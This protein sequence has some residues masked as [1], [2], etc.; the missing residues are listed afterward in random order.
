MAKNDTNTLKKASLTMRLPKELHTRIADAA[1]RELL[2][3]SAEA[4]RRLK[5]TFDEDDLAGDPRL[6]ALLRYMA[7]GSALIIET[8][9]ALKISGTARR[10]V[11]DLWLEAVERFLPAITKMNRVPADVR[12]L[13]DERRKLQFAIKRDRE[14]RG[15]PAV[16]NRHLEG[17]DLKSGKFEVQNGHLI[18][19]AVDALHHE[20]EKQ[21][22]EPSPE[23]I[24]WAELCDQIA[25]INQKRRLE[26]PER[27]GATVKLVRAMLAELTPKE[28][29]AVLRDLEE[30]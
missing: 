28:R 4:E 20:Y 19:G 3:V 11:H 14:A 10:E 7:A 23:E 1:D 15:L 16:P 18:G 5:R 25:I 13:M 26:A 24:R 30:S 21:I 27:A 12:A 22:L 2:S 17:V 6:S 29:Q 9:E 8:H